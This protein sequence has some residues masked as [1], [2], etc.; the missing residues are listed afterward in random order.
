MIIIIRKR[1]IALTAL[2]CVVL[3]GMSFVLW[4]GRGATASVFSPRDE[5]PVTVIVD[6]G[7]GGEDGGAVAKDGTIESKINLE[8][9]Q[10]LNAVL[11]FAGQNTR[12]TRTEDVSIHSPGTETMHQRKVSDL[13]NRVAL[14][15]GTEHAVLISIHQN[16][17]PSS[18]K[19]HGAQVFWNTVEGGDLLARMVQQRLNLS[20]NSGNE[21]VAKKI[22]STIY[23]MKNVTAPAII[24]ECGFLSNAEETVRLQEASY[25]RKLA[26]SIAA[27]YLACL[28]GEEVS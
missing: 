13:Q 28:A 19:T 26:I 7:H 17:L 16:S 27:G 2:C 25:Q 5:V 12:M 20:V 6:A 15:N 23:L 14:V 3:A 21:K 22:P 11:L 24:V 8:V 9:A 10:K 18:L 1:Y 4:Q